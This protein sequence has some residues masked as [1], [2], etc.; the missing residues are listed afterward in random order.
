MGQSD[1]FWEGHDFSRA[2]I[3][4]EKKTASA[5]EGHPS[6]PQ[7]E[8]FRTLKSV[9]LYFHFPV[10]STIVMYRSTGKFAN[11]SVPPGRGH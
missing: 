5:A 8:S 11:R 9:V 1:S 2:V 6:V 3:A 7:H 10:P 4:T